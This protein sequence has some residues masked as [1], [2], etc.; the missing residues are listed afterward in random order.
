VKCLDSAE[1]RQILFHDLRHTYASDLAEQGAP[2]KYVKSQLDHF[3]IQ[4]MMDIHSHLFKKSNREWVNTLDEITEKE[5]RNVS[6]HG[7]PA[8]QTQPDSLGEEHQTHKLLKNMVAVEGL[9][10][11]ARGL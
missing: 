4:V 3:S 11:P 2:P 5:V 10:P 7:K 6:G 8:T 1:L 9:E